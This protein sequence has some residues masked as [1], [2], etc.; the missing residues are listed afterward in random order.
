MANVLIGVGLGLIL[1]GLELMV[2]RWFRRRAVKQPRQTNA[3]PTAWN[4]YVQDKKKPS[5]RLNPD[6]S[7]DILTDKSKVITRQPIAVE[8]DDEIVEIDELGRVFRAGEKK[9]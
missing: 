9:P 5:V 3:G 4:L 1:F 6:G 2:R 7:V 8:Q